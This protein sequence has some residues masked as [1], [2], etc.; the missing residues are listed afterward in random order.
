MSSYKYIVLSNP[1]AGREEEYNDWYS[2]TH[3]RD[4]VKVPG[5]VAAQRFKAASDSPYAYV[6][7]YDLEGPDPDAI[8]ND[9]RSRAG[10]AEMLISN[11]LDKTRVLSVLFDPITMKV[12]S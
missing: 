3:I 5:I 11:S 8:L 2:N 7:V 12:V 1:V 6:A 9:M 10:T 4:V